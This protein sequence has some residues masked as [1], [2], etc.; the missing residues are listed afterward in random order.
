MVVLRLFLV[1]VL[2]TAVAI[3]AVILIFFMFYYGCENL[4]QYYKLSQRIP[5]IN[6]HLK[7]IAYIPDLN[8]QELSKNDC[9]ICYEDFKECPDKKIVK[10]SC[11]GKHTFHL[12]CL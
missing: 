6:E 12:E 1:S 8:D 2:I 11:T 10:L 4:H 5:K 3:W 7:S 9:V